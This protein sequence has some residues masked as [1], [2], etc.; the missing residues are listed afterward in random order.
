MIRMHNIPEHIRTSLFQYYKESEKV[1][2]FPS[3]FFIDGERYYY[4]TCAVNREQLIM[5][6]DGT[7]P[8]FQQVK[9]AALICHSYNASIESIIHIG[10]KWVNSDKKER[11]AKLKAVLATLKEK[12]PRELEHAYNAYIDAA[13]IIIENQEIIERSVKMAKEIWD[14]TNLEEL[15]TEQDQVEM[16]KCIVD[17]TRAAYRQNE[18][19]LKTEKERELIWNYVSS[20]KWSLGL[21]L[22]FSLRTYQKKM[23][24]NTPANI[25]EVEE[26]GKMV[27]GE[28]LPLEQ[29]ENAQAVLG[30]LR[31]PR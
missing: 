9:K 11:Y 12:L 21:G 22:Y 16:R 31:N 20:N 23:M 24:K 7:V 14:R 15:A 30:R 13:N 19:Q 27:L 2:V 29:H 4:F 28:D 1:D 26:T 18:I 6:E 10:N 5:K 25:R 17:M 3:K 8:Y